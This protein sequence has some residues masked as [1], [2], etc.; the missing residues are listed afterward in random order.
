MNLKYCWACGAEYNALYGEHICE[1]E[2]LNRC[3]HESDS[4]KRTRE[5]RDRIAQVQ[6]WD[7]AHPNAVRRVG[8]L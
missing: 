7:A 5:L 8:R 2:E 3:L 4:D 1:V 6:A